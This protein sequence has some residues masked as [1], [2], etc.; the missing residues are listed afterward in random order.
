[1]SDLLEFYRDRPVVVTGCASGIGHAVADKLAG[2]GA[3]VIGIDRNP[4]RAD[5]RQ[6]VETDLADPRSIA[7]AIAVLP[8][9]IWGLFNCAGLSGGA[10]DPQTVLRVNFI[11]LRELLEGTEPR[12]P[13][14]AA[15]VSTASGA[16]Q[17]FE[18]NRDEV[19]GLVRTSGFDE[20]L[21]WARE[22]DT[23]V[24]ERG[25]YP[26]SKEALILYTLE[27]CFELGERGRRINC[28]APGV[29]D[30]PMLRDSAKI[31]GEQLLTTP[32]KPLGRMATAEE[33]ANIL[34]YLNSDWASYVNGQ[35]IWSDGGNILRR[36][37]PG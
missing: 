28:I 17:D 37:L 25:G 33:Q 31:Y 19:I 5:L 14:G 26:L 24:K 13:P 22:H 10:A 21:D 3:A 30:T 6:F 9:E 29:T 20:A 12:I 15:I 32:P 11:G 35:T 23:Y 36:V 2:A 16:G 34:I 27:R 7:A 4:P 8:A 18:K 1:M